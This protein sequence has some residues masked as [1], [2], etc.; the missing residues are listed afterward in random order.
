MKIYTK[1]RESDSIF[2]LGIQRHFNLT[3]V[4]LYGIIV[5]GANKSI[6]ERIFK[7]VHNYTERV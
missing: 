5:N 6:F 4:G 7:K 2:L 1:L 3:L